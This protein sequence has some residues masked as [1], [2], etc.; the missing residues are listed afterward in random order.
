[1]AQELKDLFKT[2]I[3]VGQVYSIDET[4]GVI[5]VKYISDSGFK[6]FNIPSVFVGN[7]SWIRAYPQI[8]SY[9][10]I[11]D[12]DEDQFPE[13]I[14][15]FDPSEKARLILDEGLNIN[16]NPETPNSVTPFD[17]VA[18]ATNNAKDDLGK[19]GYP[20]R[21]LKGGEL[22]A[23][24]SG[25]AS[26]WL[27]SNGE[28]VLKGGLSKL[29]M[30]PF[31][32]TIETSSAGHLKMGLDSTLE[33]YGDQEYFGVVRRPGSNSISILSS[34]N[35]ME[36]RIAK[37]TRA[38]V[39]YERINQAI[40]NLDS[41]AVDAQNDLN[42]AHK[43]VTQLIK[44]S[45]F[46]RSITGSLTR[47]SDV[48]TQIYIR[49]LQDLSDYSKSYV[50]DSENLKKLDD[51]IAELKIWKASVDDFLNKSNRPQ[52]PGNDEA[53]LLSDI[54]S[55]SLSPIPQIDIKSLSSSISN[56]IIALPISTLQ[57]RK[58]ELEKKKNELEQSE[59]NKIKNI[60]S[61]Y[62]Y[63][64]LKLNPEANSDAVFA[65]EYRV[66][67]S[68]KGSDDVNSRTLYEKIAGHVYD[69]NGLPETYA[70][71]ARLRSRETFVTEKG[72]STN[73]YVDTFGNMVT[74]LAEDASRGY[75]LDAP[76]GPVKITSGGELIIT[77]NKSGSSTD[78]AVSKIH[79]VQ[80]NF[81]IVAGDA[82]IKM[83]N[84]KI[85]LN[86]LKGIEINGSIVNINST[87]TKLDSTT[88][89]ISGAVYATAPINVD[90]SISNKAK[91]VNQGAQGNQ[92]AV[93]NQGAQG[94][95]GAVGKNN[96]N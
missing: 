20:Y 42:I 53:T 38:E 56:E 68:W 36:N 19:I 83:T 60:E 72:S 45:N 69:S 1:M 24:S 12:T 70:N 25:K 79:I 62:L 2:K 76:G 82:S 31:K 11:A 84:G 5:E 80:G 8:G 46:L 28:L 18:K 9:V 65:K 43:F 54:Q 26:W 77:A 29:E 13:I 78:G 52:D 88:T 87:T 51:G 49:S 92:G 50:P 85:I 47:L 71:M 94:N 86:G 81:E 33:S 66:N 74:Q 40:I 41:L 15:V 30:D 75:S 23:S 93:G 27:G 67:V 89:S 59:E 61:K 39:S 14:K 57:E 10:L 63:Q 44:D 73:N 96:N 32:N 6:K 48:D 37:L 55:K 22:E 17:R 7:D 90:P 21:K 3:L 91:K 34:I 95:Q 64:S 35:T 16:E 4:N 58:A